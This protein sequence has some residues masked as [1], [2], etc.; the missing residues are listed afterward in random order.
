MT[1]LPVFSP[2]IRL[3]V[4]TVTLLFCFSIRAAAGPD[5]FP[6]QKGNYWIYR[7]K[8]KYLVPNKDESQNSGHNEPKSEIL[9]WKMEVVDTKEGANFFA[10]LIKGMPDDLSWYVPNRPRGDYLILRVGS[11]TYYIY[12]GKKA[13]T[14]WSILSDKEQ[15]LNTLDEGEIMLDGP[16]VQGKVFGGDFLN[17]VTGTRYCWNVESENSFDLKSFHNAS[18]LN[19]PREFSCVY[20]TNPDHTIMNFVP[21]IGITGYVYVHHGT[22]SE[23]DLKLIEFG[24]VE[25]SK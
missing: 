1:Q 3:L 6:L 21:G 9:T 7:G 23:A 20:R 19:N 15:K 2:F 4:F 8:T 16:L 12:T 17:R 24:T 22:L 10:A 18:Q 11:S 13:L 14:A 25:H 5:Y